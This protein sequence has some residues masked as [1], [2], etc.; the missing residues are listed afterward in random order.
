M[1]QS[2]QSYILLRSQSMYS[3]S[4]GIIAPTRSKKQLNGIFGPRGQLR[5][6]ILLHFAVIAD[7]RD[8]FDFFVWVGRVNFLFLEN[9][10]TA[11]SDTGLALRI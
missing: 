11:W 1:S 6:Y 3:G 4:S 10:S 8:N 5:F 2:K 7:N 9:F